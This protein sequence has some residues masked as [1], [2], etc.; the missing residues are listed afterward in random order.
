MTEDAPNTTPDLRRPQPGGKPDGTP[1]AHTNQR[2]YTESGETTSKEYL[3]RSDEIFFA[4]VETTRMPMIVTDPHTPDNQI[5]FANRAFLAMTGYR[6]EDIVGTNC[7][8]LQGPGTD[9]ETVTAIRNAIASRSEIATEILNYRKNGSSFWNAL[10][11]SP[12][13]DQ[14]GDLLYFFGSQLDVSR[15]RDAEDALRQAQKMEALGQLT[16][17][18][19]HDFNNLLQVMTG[20]HELSIQAIE[21]GRMD[22]DRMLRNLRAAHDAATRAATLT[23]Q[24]LSFAR[25]QR[26]EGR[27]LNL[28]E[29]LSGMTEVI[30]RTLG[31]DTL[32]TLTLDRNLPN[33]R[34]DPSQCEVALLNIVINARDA[35]INRPLKSV[36]IETS[37]LTLTQTSP[38]DHQAIAPGRYAAIRIIDTGCG[39][40]EDIRHRVLDPFFTTKEEGR[41]TGLGL[42]MVYGFVKQSGGSIR[43]AS[44]L[45]EG[46]TIEL[47]FP[48]HDDQKQHPAALGNALSELNGTETIL[49]VEDR[50]D[51]AD[52]AQAFL[53]DFGYTTLRAEHARAAL[54]ILHARQDIDLLFTDLVMPGTMNGV[55]L[56]RE[57]RTLRPGIRCLLTTGYAETSLEHTDTGTA[58]FDIIGKPYRKQDLGR[59]IRYILNEAASSP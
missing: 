23:Q 58:E 28:N 54:D 2:R 26:L 10:F 17:G 35:L 7:R 37:A 32:L 45:D 52:L 30:E 31:P 33:A 9:P 50:E 15:R 11:I 49:I 14:N 8:F 1:D 46:T 24:L 57:A 43:I 25:K 59:K 29:T 19:A 48:V 47:L 6:P 39:M 38:T 16:G 27:A 56:A 3:R 40:P 4:A 12:V 22:P 51:V 18:I 34:L 41:G 42:S 13:Y 20:Y 21:R 53:D 44:R 36:T 5:I 55:M